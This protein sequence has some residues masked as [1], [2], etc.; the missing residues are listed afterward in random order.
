LQSRKTLP[1]KKKSLVIYCDTAASRNNTLES[2]KFYRA[3][4]MF[5]KY[6]GHPIVLHVNVHLLL[7]AEA[8]NNIRDVIVPGTIGKLFEDPNI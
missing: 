3:P 5:E 7:R 8:L 2:L 4:V 1:T 6:K